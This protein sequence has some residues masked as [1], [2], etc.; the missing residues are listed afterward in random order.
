MIY[1][2]VN[3]E[4]E[5]T[6][7]VGLFDSTEKAIS[8]ALENFKNEHKKLSGFFAPEEFQQKFETIEQLNKSIEET[9]FRSYR[10]LDEFYYTII[11]M[12]VNK[13]IE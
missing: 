8:G 10:H 3:W 9:K 7:V 11:Q 2:A 1:E 13:V 4:F 5:N 6:I 12:E